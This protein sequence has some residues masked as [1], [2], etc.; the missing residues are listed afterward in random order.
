L[1]WEKG[2]NSLDVLELNH[3][4][5]PFPPQHPSF[6]PSWPEAERRDM[7]RILNNVKDSA[8]GFRQFA[9]VWT[10]MI[11]MGRMFRSGCV[12]SM[13]I[14]RLMFWNRIILS[15]L[16]DYRGPQHPSSDNWPLSELGWSGWEGCSGTFELREGLLILCCLG[17]KSSWVSVSS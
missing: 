2:Y 7:L 11:R 6:A 8:A 10:R 14:T 15:I 13:C 12:V 17:I 5:Y 1:S 16:S 4:E 9:A 3:P